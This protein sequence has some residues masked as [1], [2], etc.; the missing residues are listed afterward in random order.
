MMRPLWRNADSGGHG[1]GG[2]AGGGTVANLVYSTSYVL[3]FGI[4]FPVAMLATTVPAGSA[5]ARGVADGTHAARAKV[6]AVTGR[7]KA[8]PEA[9]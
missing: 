8:S 7:R 3:A 4:A 1:H 2:T 9:Q 5:L 6:D